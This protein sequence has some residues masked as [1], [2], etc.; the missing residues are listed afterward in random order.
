MFATY[1]TQKQ[2]KY[3]VSY[4]FKR[5][6]CALELD[7]YMVE[8][9]DKYGAFLKTEF[10]RGSTTAFIM[11]LLDDGIVK[12]TELSPHLYNIYKQAYDEDEIW[13]GTAD[14]LEQI[15]RQFITT[16]DELQNVLYKF[17]ECNHQFHIQE[18]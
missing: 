14:E 5:E 11:E 16:V 12:P 17:D 4:A 2:R 6:C 15:I 18:V 9:I 7:V 3:V 8:A 13:T 10:I 1:T